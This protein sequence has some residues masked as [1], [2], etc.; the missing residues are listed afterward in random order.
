MYRKQKNE[1]L[2]QDHIYKGS[3]KHTQPTK[4][5]VCPV[6]FFVKK[7]Y[8]FTS[9]KVTGNTKHNREEVTKLLREFLEA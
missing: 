6:K 9:Y 4:K 8:R 5:M 1:A 2:K 7:T 3:R